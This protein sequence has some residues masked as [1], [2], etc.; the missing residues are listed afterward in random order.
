MASG[1]RPLRIV[2][3][4]APWTRAIEEH[5]VG[6]PGITLECASDPG[7]APARFVA[8]AEESLAVGENGVRRL[9]LDIER[10]APPTGIPVFFGPEHMQRNVLVAADASMTGPKDLEGRRVGSRLSAVSGTGAGVLMMLELGYGVDLERIQ[11]HLG[12]P[13]AVAVN[14]MGLD[15]HPGPSTDAEAVGQLAAGELDALIVTTG[16]RYWSFFGPDHVDPAVRSQVRPLVAD[17]ETIAATYRRTRVYPITDVAVAKPL[18]RDWDSALPRRLVEAFSEANALASEYRDDQEEALARR[19]IEL[20]GADPHQYM[21]GP[22][23]RRSLA[24]FIDFLYRIGA[25]AAPLEP[26]ALFLP[27]A[28]DS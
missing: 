13:A 12:D 23:Q 19:E 14:R 18:V 16:P 20:L 6:V 15:L 9:I 28:L 7:D 5:R 25:I 10:G 3:P 21:L 11:W 8:T 17:P 26:E 4:S 1:A 2:V 27:E 24:A 22:D